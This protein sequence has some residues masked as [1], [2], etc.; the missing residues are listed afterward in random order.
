MP[1]LA[2][3]SHKIQTTKQQQAAN[4]KLKN[5]AGGSTTQPARYARGSK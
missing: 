4:K 3:D 2:N 5:E 1:I